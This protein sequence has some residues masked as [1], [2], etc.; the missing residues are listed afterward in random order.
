MTMKAIEEFADSRIFIPDLKRGGE[1]PVFLHRQY[2]TFSNADS[3]C[4]WHRPHSV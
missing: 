2:N 1:F 4:P 3:L